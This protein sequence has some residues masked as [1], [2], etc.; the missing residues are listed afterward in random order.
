MRALA[1]AAAAKEQAE[2]ERIMA[3]KQN[4]RRQ[5]EAEELRRRADYDREIA[6]LAANKVEAVANAKLKAIQESIRMKKRHGSIFQRA[7]KQN[8]RGKRVQT[9]YTRSRHLFMTWELDKDR[10]TEMIVRLSTQLKKPYHLR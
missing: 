3:D 4:E 9:W 5:H 10:R 1:E 7:R 6:I 2:F 8:T